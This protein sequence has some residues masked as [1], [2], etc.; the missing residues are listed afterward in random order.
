MG[1]AEDGR[2]RT[3]MVDGWLYAMMDESDDSKGDTG[4][5]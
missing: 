1:N 2:W 5:H 4:N 3:T